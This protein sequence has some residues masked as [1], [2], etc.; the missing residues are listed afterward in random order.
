MRLFG[1]LFDLRDHPLTRSY[2]RKLFRRAR[3]L[4]CSRA[5]ANDNDFAKSANA[6]EPAMR[7]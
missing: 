6:G 5:M 4:K 3:F 2:S 1:S 7:H